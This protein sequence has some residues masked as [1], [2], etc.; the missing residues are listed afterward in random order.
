M[1]IYLIRHGIAVERGIYA[2]DAARP[3]TTQGIKRTTK[4]AQKLA[5]LNLQFDYL[6]SSPLVRARETAEILQQAGLATTVISDRNLAPAGN[7][8]SW[9]SWLKANYNETA[10]V[11]LVGHQ[12][13][14]GNWAELLVF[15][16]IKQNLRLKKAGIIGLKIYDSLNSLRNSEMFLLVS[17]KWLLIDS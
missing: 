12:P 4:I 6:L 3:L 5:K 15:G 17:P 7:I 9:L 14:L 2:E 8:N 10:K 11:A 1:E 16:E 13:D